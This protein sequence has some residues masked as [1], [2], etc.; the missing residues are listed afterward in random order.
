[1]KELIKHW[2]AYKKTVDERNKEESKGL[3][4]GITIVP[5]TARVEEFL[6]YIEKTS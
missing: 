1:M 3:P 6:D 4:E 5:Y 2:K